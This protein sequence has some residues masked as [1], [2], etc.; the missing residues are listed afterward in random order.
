MGKHPKR[1]HETEQV[2]AAQS[3]AIDESSPEL[4]LAFSSPGSSTV[5]AA[6]YDP[7]TRTLTVEFTT[8]RYQYPNVDVL[9]WEE[10]L[11]AESKGGYFSAR[12]RPM[13]A[14]VKL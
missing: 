12:I 6:S 10:F 14:G 9:L 4:P 5:K 13:F 2:A 3:A 11:D 8:A 7:R 1:T